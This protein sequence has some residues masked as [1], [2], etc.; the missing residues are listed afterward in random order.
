MLICISI[1]PVVTTLVQMVRKRV[2]N[3]WKIRAY[4]KVRTK[5][6]HSVMRSFNPMGEGYRFDKV[7]YGT[8][9]GWRNKPRPPYS[10]DLYPFVVFIFLNF[11][12]KSNL[13]VVKTHEKLSHVIDSNLPKLVYQKWIQRLKLFILSP[14]ELFEGTWCWFHFL[15]RMLLKYLTIH[16]TYKENIPQPINKQDVGVF[17]V[18]E[19]F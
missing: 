11:E 15:S 3:I 1:S 9:F 13:V 18:W 8:V 5:L 2:D 10:L 17:F 4:T 19:T 7:F 16:I 6:Y 14:G 12:K